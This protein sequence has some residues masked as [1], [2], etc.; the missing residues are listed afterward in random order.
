MSKSIIIYIIIIG[1]LLRITMGV[2][3]PP[4]N[5]YDDHLEPISKY[6]NT[7]MRP[8]PDECWECYQPPLYYFLS[9]LVY[10][11]AYFLTNNFFISWKA[12]QF[13]NVLLSIL[14]LYV[15]FLILRRCTVE[16]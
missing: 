9:S 1:S 16:R 10:K 13:I 5:S 8:A 3:N 14:N 4:N 15:I 11:S 2:I 12:V 7:G 6:I